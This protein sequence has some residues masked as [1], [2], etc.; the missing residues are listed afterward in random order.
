MRRSGLHGNA[1]CGQKLCGWDGMKTSRSVGEVECGQPFAGS[2][3]IELR[4]HLFA[5]AE[6]CKVGIHFF[7]NA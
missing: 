5:K 4:V 2:R 3:Y 7:L 1:S 6:A